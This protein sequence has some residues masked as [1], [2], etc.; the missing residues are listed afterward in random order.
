VK[1]S[2]LIL[3]HTDPPQLSRLIK[4]L[5]G[6]DVSFY[7]HIDRKSS[8]ETF[9][10]VIK[11]APNVHFLQQ[12]VPVMWG[13]FS[14]VEATLL[15][16]RAALAAGPAFDYAI[17]LSGLDYPIK[18]RR[19]VL[20]FF[21]KHPGRQYLRYAS[22]ADNPSLA[23]KVKYYYFPSIQWP[24]NHRIVARLRYKLVRFL[25]PRRSFLPNLVP[26]TGS[27]WWALT[28]D[29]LQYVVN[30]VDEHWEYAECLCY[31][32][33]PDETFFHTLVLNS[34][35]GEHTNR[36]I[37]VGKWPNVRQPVREAGEH[38]KYLDWKSPREKPAILE[39][40]DF[41]MLCKSE[42]LFA[43]KFTT[44]KSLR[45]IEKLNAEVLG[46]A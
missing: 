17:L 39:E 1:L 28:K 25:L 14:V 37:Q 5:D 33:I 20:D 2:Y 40:T 36:N 3:A 22:I 38:I 32:D 12:R 6:E 8:L 18:P 46:K 23:Y 26:Y 41:N 24:R 31:A 30:Y 29:C 4:A 21:G 11:P 7:I 34:P 15:L 10:S 27:Q 43:R 45:L 16:I 9:T 19:Y 42:R 13:G 35:F 44:A